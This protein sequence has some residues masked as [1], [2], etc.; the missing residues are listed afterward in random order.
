[1]KRKREKEIVLFSMSYSIAC[2]SKGSF[3]IFGT[4]Q[5]REGDKKKSSKNH[6]A[7]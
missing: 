3:Y 1:M 4:L 6:L 7:S 2:R 5:V